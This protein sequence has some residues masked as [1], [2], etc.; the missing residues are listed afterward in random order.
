MLIAFACV[1]IFRAAV[2]EAFIIPT[3]SMAPTLLGQHVRLRS[4]MTGESWAVGSSR[5]RGAEDVRVTDPYT[6]LRVGA[7][8]APVGA[9][10]RIFVYK[11]LSFFRTP[12]RWSVVVF[13]NPE[14]PR[15]NYIKR[16]VGLPGEEVWLVHGDVFVRT[17]EGS[18]GEGSTGGDDWRI[19]RKP[20]GVQIGLWRTLFS[21]EQ[22]P[23]AEC[24][25]GARWRSPWIVTDA[26]GAPVEFGGP[27]LSIGDDSAHTLEWDDAL[28]PVTDRVAYND[29]P[30]LS[31][32]PVFPASDARV[33]FA[34]LPRAEGFEATA[35]ITSLAHDFRLEVGAGRARLSM[36]AHASADA[37]WTVLAEEPHA[38]FAP[39]E[40]ASVSFAFVDQALEA[41]VN[42]RPVARVEIGWSPFE[43]L[44]YAT[45][46]DEETLREILAD[47]RDTVLA[48]PS[49]YRNGGARARLTVRGAPATLARVGL[50]RDVSYTPVE[51]MAGPF[52]GEMGMGTHPL[53]PASL[54]AR[55]VFVLG[56]N[57]GASRDGRLWD[58]VDP[59]VAAQIGPEVGVVP[60]DL[61]VG[62]AFMVYFPAPHEVIAAGAR[63]PLVPDVGRVRRIR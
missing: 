51:R 22:A 13:K 30:S 7:E 16:L 63:R 9:G 37:G 49:L 50:D 8:R 15:E 38:G 48:S 31:G 24:L 29:T 54:S 32:A 52:A 57:S 59:L 6:L 44:R 11:P 36:R 21:S 28:H 26:G 60:L 55:Q 41:C 56:D 20:R 27:T 3:G 5:A 23:L 43:R 4:P 46:L 45:G 10:D 62:R 33:R 40:W 53:R 1:L 12:G 18:V 25:E 61:L 58:T 35:I 14:N 2:V 39:G 19:A 34:A 17:R 42:E 47:P